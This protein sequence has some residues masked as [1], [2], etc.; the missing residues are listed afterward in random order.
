[1]GTPSRAPGPVL[2][3]WCWPGWTARSTTLTWSP[4]SAGPARS[5]P[6]PARMD[7]AV[8][9]AIGSIEDD[10]WTPIKYPNAL[11]DE[12]EQAWISIAEGAETTY[13]AFTPLRLSAQVTGRL[14]VRR[15]HRQQPRTPPGRE[16]PARPR[17]R[18]AGHRRPQEWP[19]R[20]PTLRVL[21]RQC[22]LAGLRRDRVQPDPRLRVSRLHLSRPHE[23]HHHPNPPGHGV[24]TDR[25]LR[26]T[27]H[28][29]PT[30]RLALGTR[31]A[32]AVH[33]DQRPAASPSR[34][35]TRPWARPRNHSGAA[36]PTGEPSM[37]GAEGPQR[38]CRQRPS[39][40]KPVDPGSV[41]R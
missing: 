41:S 15:V 3:L 17:D 33:R 28:P 2:R 32:R 31:L 25:V 19:S 13:T 10:G 9:A 5:S 12:A 26:P 14:I 8:P 6:S 24:R 38:P 37:P 35:I 27:A 39:G 34:L 30:A 21:Q 20:S 36:G 18:R 4:R 40:I 11:W 1:M 16:L 23:D 7:K 22:R 29:A